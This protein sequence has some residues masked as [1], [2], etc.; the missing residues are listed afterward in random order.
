[1]P[2][3]FH[4]LQGLYT[5]GD[6]LCAVDCVQ[7]LPEY[8]HVIFVNHDD[9]FDEREI[10][11]EVLAMRRQPDLR[12]EEARHASAVCGAA[13]WT[14]DEQTRPPAKTVPLTRKQ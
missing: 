5:A 14:S 1:M 4:Q 9:W 12:P 3:I 10:Y 2:T 8:D 7:A 11:W 13:A 6:V